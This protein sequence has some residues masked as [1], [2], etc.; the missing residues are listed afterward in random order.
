MRYILAHHS[1]PSSVVVVVVVCKRRSTDEALSLSTPGTTH[2]KT[3][4]ESTF[5]SFFC[6]AP[7]APA[8]AGM[9]PMVLEWRMKKRNEPS[10]TKE[11]TAIEEREREREIIHHL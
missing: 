7:A 1:L 11:R 4:I 10:N 6:P 8:P 2:K 3:T 9:E 5:L